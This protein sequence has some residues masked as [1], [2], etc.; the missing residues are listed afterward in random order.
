MVEN[1]CYY[2]NSGDFVEEVST[3][4]IFSNN[5]NATSL[6]GSEIE[7]EDGIFK[8]RNKNKKRWRE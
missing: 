4:G 1:S 3:G 8:Q 2:F 7:T 6:L 5:L